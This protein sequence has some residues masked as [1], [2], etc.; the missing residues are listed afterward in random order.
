MD[1]N[2]DRTYME[3]STNELWDVVRLKDNCNRV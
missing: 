1:A 2:E 3:I